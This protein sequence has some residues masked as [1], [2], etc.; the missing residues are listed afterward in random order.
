MKNQKIETLQNELEVLTKRFN[1]N[2][3]KISS[4]LKFTKDQEHFSNGISEVTN[5]EKAI[6]ERL[7]LIKENFQINWARVDIIRQLKDS[8]NKM[9]SIESSKRNAICSGDFFENW[10]EDYENKG[11]FLMVEIIDILNN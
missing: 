3:K 9:C 11:D 2:M 6:N 7:L 1:D 10:K 5:I 8:Q 4:L